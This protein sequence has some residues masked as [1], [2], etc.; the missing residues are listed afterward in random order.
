[1]Y[2][3]ISSKKYNI[4]DI[5]YND[6]GEYVLIKPIIPKKKFEVKLILNESIYDFQYIHSILG[7]ISIYT[8]KAP[9]KEDNIILLKINNNEI[10][11]KINN[12]P[13]FEN[14][15][16]M[17]TMV[18]NEDNYI[19]QWINYHSKLGVNRFIIYDNAGINDKLSYSSKEKKS[20][21]KLVL[22]Q[23]ID[24]KKVVLIKWPYKKR[25]FRKNNP[26]GQTGQQ[27]HSLYLFRKSKYIGFL[28]IDEYLNPKKKIE[29][30]DTYFNELIVKNKINIDKISSFRFKTRYFYNPNNRND[31]GNNFLK[32]FNCDNVKDERNKLF[33]IPKNT[34]IIKIHWVINGLPFY[35]VK[36]ID[37]YLNHYFYLNKNNRGKKKTRLIDK[38]ILNN[39]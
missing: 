39:I 30:I 9:K 37:G 17:S 16:I 24:K 32:I 10:T 4:Y 38:S 12:Y 7:G 29:N 26:C 1:M 18:K 5:F 8:V 35:S 20:N 25:L 14:E 2:N 21:L 33:V 13:I 31:K 11:V 22:K 36:G 34:N 15:I 27:N 28:D 6:N 3:L 23:Y 19:K